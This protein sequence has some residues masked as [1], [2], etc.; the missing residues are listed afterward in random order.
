MSLG[1][2]LELFNVRGPRVD[3]DSVPTESP[4]PTLSECGEV[5]GRQSLRKEDSEGSLNAVRTDGEVDVQ[6]RVNTTVESYV[7]TDGRD[8]IREGVWNSTGGVE[9]GMGAG[10]KGVKG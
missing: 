4:L 3:R 1:A 10:V 2:G 5:E 7:E 8:T 9:S 6:E